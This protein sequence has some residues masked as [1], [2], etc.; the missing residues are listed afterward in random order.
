MAQIKTNL[1][2]GVTGSLQTGSIA[3]DAIDGTKIADDAIN[4]E[5]LVDGGVD[6][7]HLATGISSSK[8]SGALPAISGAS[9]TGITTGKILQV[10]GASLS[11][12]YDTS[13]T[14]QVE[15]ITA[16]ITPSATSS[17]ILVY[18]SVPFCEPSNT[19]NLG[20]YF[21]IRAISGGA[22][23][24]LITTGHNSTLGIVDGDSRQNSSPCA[25]YLDSPSTTSAITYKV[26]ISVDNASM[27]LRWNRNAVGQASTMFMILQEV[28]G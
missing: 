17:K 6:D 26:N 15:T 8:L 23:T 27:N 18:F 25:M 16:T 2:Y 5:H 12:T 7:A 1:Q 28:S 11:S 14:S 4:S 21:L 9:L 10:I 24:D 13:S 20:Q 3:G 22:S 19:T